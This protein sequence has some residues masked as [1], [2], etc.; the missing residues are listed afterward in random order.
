MSRLTIASSNFT[1]NNTPKKLEMWANIFLYSSPI[2]G[3]AVATAPFGDPLLLSWIAGIW[4]AVVIAFK[5]IS[6][7]FGINTEAI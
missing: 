6:K 4:N 3:I 5:G 2:I 7:I 1:K